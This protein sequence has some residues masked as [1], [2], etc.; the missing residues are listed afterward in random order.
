LPGTDEQKLIWKKNREKA[1]KGSRLHFVRSWYA[2]NL[3]KEGFA[4]EKV[5]T[6]SKTLKTTPIENPYDTSL[7][8][9]I[10]NNDVEISY[11]GKIRVL[12][13]NAPPDPQYLRENKMP[14]SIIA[15]ISILDISD[16][17]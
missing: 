2:H 3:E 14:A 16:G 5:D 9:V 11:N 6:T 7:L 8:Q 1:Y 10:E 13:K 4:I 12:Y 17:L 15:Q